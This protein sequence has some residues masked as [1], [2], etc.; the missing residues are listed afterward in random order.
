MTTHAVMTREFWTLADANNITSL[1]GVPSTYEM[2]RRL[3]VENRGLRRLRMLTQAGGR[4]SD[5]LI[6]YFASLAQNSG[7]LFFVMYGQTEA[8]PRISYVPPA[9]LAEKVGSI[10][11]PIPGGRLEIE[12][13]TGE[14]IYQ[15]PNVMMGYA[16]SRN[17]IGKP[18]ECR[19][20]LRTGD[21]GRQ[22]EEGFFYITGRL[23][24]FVKLSGSRINLDE[25][26]IALSKSIAG[27]LACVGRDDRLT[28]VLQADATSTD[29]EVKGHL[30]DLFDVFAGSVQIHRI[31]AI[32][33]L[34]SGKT[35][36]QALEQLA[37][38]H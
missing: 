9:R 33:E 19:G 22:D 18:D 26:E 28:V 17:E 11:I 32:P 3:G 13:Q 38:S 25:V 4:L 6:R 21:L 16:V 15:G 34:A 30:R 10:G 24:R 23:S 14:L 37:G 8:S 1:S 36:Y 31:P 2:L 27:S 12:Q 20:V 7:W 29:L 35:D 5:V